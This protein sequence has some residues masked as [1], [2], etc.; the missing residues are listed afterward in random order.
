[1]VK[2]KL[3]Q[4]YRELVWQACFINDCEMK[5]D[6]YKVLIG[7]AQDMQ[8]EDRLFFIDKMLQIPLN[9]IIDREVELV[10]NLSSALRG[11]TDCEDIQQRGLK[12]IWNIS[13]GSDENVPI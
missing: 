9:K 6:L 2:G 13:M 10:T 3:S 1:M 7:A 5:I 8:K 4:E 12:F 11:R